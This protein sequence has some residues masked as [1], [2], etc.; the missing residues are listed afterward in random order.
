MAQSIL[1]GLR[2]RLAGLAAF[3]TVFQSAASHEPTPILTKATTLT[4][5]P[6]LWINSSDAERF[7][8]VAY[9]LGWVLPDFD[10]GKWCETPEAKRLFEHPSFVATATAEQLGQLLTAYIRGDRFCDGT[11]AS[12]WKSGMLMAIV[13]R[14]AMLSKDIKAH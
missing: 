11:L 4:E 13:Q 10:W 1:P 3:V 8:Q 5:S 2:D 7:V 9:D 14:A 6:A 12:A